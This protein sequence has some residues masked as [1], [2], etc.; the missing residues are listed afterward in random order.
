MFKYTL[1]DD[2]ELFE[3]WDISVGLEKQKY[4]KTLRDIGINYIWSL[5]FFI[6]IWDE[7]TLKIMENWDK[8]IMINNDT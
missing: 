7:N 1:F 3:F 8:K 4:L 2:D 6:I 5:Y